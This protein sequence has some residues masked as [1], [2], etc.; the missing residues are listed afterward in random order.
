MRN[1]RRR[2]VPKGVVHQEI[3]LISES[4]DLRLEEDF[5]PGSRSIS[6]ELVSKSLRERTKQERV[7]ERLV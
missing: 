1:E 2:D 3:Q 5:R 6:G 7:V 4:L